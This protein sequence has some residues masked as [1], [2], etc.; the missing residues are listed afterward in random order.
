MI[1]QKLAA[2]RILV[3]A[4]SFFSLSA[5]AGAEEIDV[6][7]ATKV[8]VVQDPQELLTQF[9]TAKQNIRNLAVNFST[10]AGSVDQDC[11]CAP[12]VL[13]ANVITITGVSPTD[14]FRNGACSL[15]RPVDP[16][17]ACPTPARGPMRAGFRPLATRN[18]HGG[19]QCVN[20]A[21]CLMMVTK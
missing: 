18:P 20:D 2:N 3:I 9:S 7:D 1:K 5:E 21:C 10:F 19:A 11:A 4:F 16:N 15:C 12:F 13:S 8:F 6:G 17:F 14:V